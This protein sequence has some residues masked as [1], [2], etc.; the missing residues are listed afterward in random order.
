MDRLKTMESFVR[1]VKAGSFAGAA[2]QLGVSRAIVSKHL[3]DLEEYLG[4]R[5]DR[6]STRLNSSH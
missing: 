3:Q 5:L 2:S 4:A 6:K 1:V